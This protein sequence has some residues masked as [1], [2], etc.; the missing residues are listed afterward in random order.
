M[1]C[2]D[3]VKSCLLLLCATLWLASC[4]RSGTE[5]TLLTGAFG[6]AFGEQPEGLG[7]TFLSELRTIP[8]A[9]PP[10]PD[11]RFEKYSYTVTPGSHRIYQINALTGAHL[12]GPACEALRAEL[13]A[14]LK[15]MYYRDD[16][17]VINDHAGKWT[18]QRPAKRAVTLECMQASP[19]PGTDHRARYR[20]SLSY[21]DYNLAAEAYKEWNNNMATH[22]PDKY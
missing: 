22:K 21:L 2:A 6:F 10:S 12:A 14:E 11:A 20:L 18:L 13:A 8:A 5:D 1:R 17:A 9:E 3:N 7:D 16:G 19:Q 4:G 15:Q